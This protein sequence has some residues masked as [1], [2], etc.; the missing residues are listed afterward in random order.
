MNPEGI[1]MLR[2]V[3]QR[4]R[5]KTIEVDALIEL[6]YRWSD[7]QKLRSIAVEKI[8]KSGLQKPKG[9]IP[10]NWIVLSKSPEI[11]FIRKSAKL[12]RV[13]KD[14]SKRRPQLRQLPGSGG[15]IGIELGETKRVSASKKGSSDT[16]RSSTDDN[17]WMDVGT[18]TSYLRKEAQLR[19]SILGP[20]WSD[21]VK[22]ES[23]WRLKI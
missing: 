1:A 21:A 5:H 4:G 8:V 20:S 11:D 13:T 6:G 16:F 9:G 7:I 10:K 23:R 12:Q 3:D 15:N 19:L 14:G 17:F 22:G 2:F 18:F